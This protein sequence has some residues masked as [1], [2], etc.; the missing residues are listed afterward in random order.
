[1]NNLEKELENWDG[2]NMDAIKA[3]YFNYGQDSNFSND[4]IMLCE[5]LPSMHIATTWLL[6]HHLENKKTLTPSAVDRFCLLSN[7]LEHW[8]AQLHFLQILPKVNLNPKHAEI[9][10]PFIDK[11]LIS[12]NKF[13]KAWAFNALAICTRLIP[14]L[15]PE[16]KMRFDIALEEEAASVKA[17][18]RK[19]LKENQLSL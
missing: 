3:V 14:D 5:K 8:E 6:K 9:L 15:W 19:A 10:L 18:I 12:S 7:V 2:K 17:R 11:M 1:M 13:V 16:M 4:L